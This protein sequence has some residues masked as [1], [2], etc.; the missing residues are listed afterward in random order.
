MK[1]QHPGN[2]KD[3]GFSDQEQSTV[4]AE[5]L[6]KE[7][8]HTDSN[9]QSWPVHPKCN[10][11]FPPGDRTGHCAACCRT[12]YGENG[13]EAHRRGKHGE[14][15]HCIDPFTDDKHTWR[16]DGQGRWR[17]GEQLTDEAKA[18]IWGERK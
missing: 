13:F 7:T 1:Q 8:T 14:S 16:Q 4:S 15:R 18:R 10:S 9:R 11:T 6:S 3:R 5:T 12:F 17:L 2:E